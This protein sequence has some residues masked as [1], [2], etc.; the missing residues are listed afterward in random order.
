MSAEAKARYGR[1]YRQSAKYRATKAREEA[2]LKADPEREERYRERARMQC[3]HLRLAV[4]F[5]Y[6]PNCSCC[7]ES[8]PEFLG[9]DHVEGG[10][11]QHRKQIKM[12]IYE[13]LLKHGFP[14][15]YR[16]LCHNCNMSH[17]FYGYCPHERER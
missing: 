12:R 4:L 1:K 11:R 5:Y 2:R 6:G 14:E 16:V 13:W 15:G 7:G 10:G 17:G 3:V 9:I 8:R